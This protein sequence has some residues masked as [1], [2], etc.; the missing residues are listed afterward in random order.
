MV[1]SNM[2]QCKIDDDGDRGGDGELMRSPEKE[3]G[4]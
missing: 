2:I 3:R 1:I 4:W